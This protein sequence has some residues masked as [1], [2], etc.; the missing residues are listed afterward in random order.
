MRLLTVAFVAV[1]VYVG[2]QKVA[3]QAS[4]PASAESSSIGKF[5]GQQKADKAKHADSTTPQVLSCTQCANCCTVEQPH[6]QSETEK[7]QAAS[8]DRLYRRYMWAT[9]IGVAGGF[10]GVVLIFWQN[11]LVGRSVKLAKASADT[12][13]LSAQA[14]INSE[15]PWVVIF[16][17]NTKRGAFFRAGNSGRTPAEIISFSAECKCVENLRELPPEPEFKSRKT[18]QIKI[19]MPGGKFGES[20]DIELLSEEEFVD[21]ADTCRR[22]S[23]NR[24]LGVAPKLSVL[25]FRVI[26]T[27]AGGPV[28]PNVPPYESRACFCFQPADAGDPLGVCGNESY[29]RYT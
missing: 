22:E 27:H 4:P 7:A 15:R 24:P 16:A 26:Y 18:P 12:A 8:L 6:T 10:I 2:A 14:V 28:M 23:G 17:A 21:F 13:L 20:Q 25:Y 11:I 19:L 5:N 1:L 3:P 29:N 9:I